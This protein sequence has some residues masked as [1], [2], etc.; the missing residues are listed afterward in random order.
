MA[1]SGHTFP[2][3]TLTCPNCQTT[4]TYYDVSGSSYYGCPN[5]HAF[6]KYENE[7]PPEILTTFQPST[8]TPVLPIGSEGYLNGQFVRVVGLLHKKEAGSFYR[9]LEYMLL[10]QD[11]RYSQLAE[12]NG[13]WMVIEPTD[14]TYSHYHVGGKTYTINTDEGQYWLY[15][16]YKP[17]LLNAVGEFDWN[18]LEDEKLTISEYIRPPSMLI[19]EQGATDSKWYKARYISRSELATAFGIAKD[20]LPAPSGVGAIEPA[21]PDDRS[22]TLLAFTGMLLVAVFVL[23]V[24]LSI[25]KPSTQLLKESYQT[26]SDS[27]GTIKPI[28]TSS[29]DVDGPT[30]LA[31]NLSASLDN[32]WIEL[33]VTLINEQSGRVYEF[34]KTLE[35]YYGVEGGESWSEGSRDDDAVLSRIPSGRYH[36]NIYPARDLG[37]PVSFSIGITQNT[38]LGSNIALL[39]LLFSIYP[40]S[41]FVNKQWHESQRWSNSDYSKVYTEE[42]KS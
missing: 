12:Y 42:D 11:G 25:V 26:E 32:Q 13:H 21:D 30:V 8:A 24:I 31:F 33:P 36:V 27:S 35:Y 1:L 4:I 20:V 23:Q 15:N 22:G 16:Q 39:L 17:E 6:F 18:C 38:M 9:W 7:G 3:A 29:F 41:L 37:K 10:R 28:I 34:S 19:S 5:C 40:I 14:H 2:S